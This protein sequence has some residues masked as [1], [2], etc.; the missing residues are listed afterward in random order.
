MA[1]LTQAGISRAVV[2]STPG[3][4][5]ERL[6]REAPERVVPFLRPY[7][8]RA[9]R[10]D[11]FRDPQIPSWVQARLER[12]P[13]RGIGEF[14]VFGDDA[15]SPVVQEV[16]ALARQ[17]ELALMAHTDPEGIAAILDQAPDIDV[18]WAHA[19]FDVPLV[20]L[21]SLLDAH[22]RLYLELSFREG[23]MSAGRLTTAWHDFLV[24]NSARCLAG[25]DTYSPQRWAGLPAI[26]DET[27]QWLAQLPVDV[28]KRIASGNA[29]DLFVSA[30]QRPDMQ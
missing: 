4:G 10:Y 1:L 29:G 2:S 3:E 30:G 7:P 19:G 14:H 21:Q 28:A 18:I 27:R 11:W 20:G 26:L 22:P 15:A 24:N 17:R 6:Y 8:L 9:S 25:S 23:M 16:I 5:A 12:T 13:Y